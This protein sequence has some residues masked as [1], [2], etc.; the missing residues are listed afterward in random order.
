MEKFQIEIVDSNPPK[1]EYHSKD[2]N[3]LNPIYINNEFGNE[4]DVVEF[5]IMDSNHNIL[6]N[7]YDFKNY[8][9]N[10]TINNTNNFTQIKLNPE[11]DILS[12]GYSDGDYV[13]CYNFYR[14]LLGSSNKNH[15]YISNISLDRKEL[16]LSNINMTY[17]ILN[18]KYIKYSINKSNRDFYSDFI[19]NFGN[20]FNIIGVNILINPDGSNSDVFI[21]LYEP[22]P[23]EYS[24]K[25]T[26][27]ISEVISD[28]ISYNIS[29]EI[30]INT[31][32]DSEYLLGPNF[33][34]DIND[35]ITTNTQYF[36]INNILSGADQSSL[37]HLKSLADNIDINIDFNDFSNFIH[38]SS[39][40]ERLENFL[41]KLTQLE[42]LEGD[43]NVINSITGN[44]GNSS[45]NIKNE[46]DYILVNLD[47]YEQFLYYNSGSDS[48]PKTG[49]SKPYINQSLNSLE[50]KEWIGSI[51]DIDMHYGGKLLDAFNFDNSNRDYLWNNLPDY[52]KLDEQNDKL[53]L[54]TSMLGQHFDYLWTFINDI[55]NK[56]NNDNRLNV[57]ISKDLVAETLKSFGIKLYTNSRNNDNI[58]LSLLGINPDNT[59]LPTTG[60]YIIDNYVTASA[61]TI[62]D[63]DINKEVYK[64]IYNNLPYLL[65]SKGTKNGLKSL[66]NCFGIPETILRIKEYGDINKDIS[67]I[68]NVVPK[69]NYSFNGNYS[70]INIPWD[71]L[72]KEFIVSSTLKTPSNIEFRFKSNND[73]ST[74]ILQLNNAF[75]VVILNSII[76]LSING[77]D[78]PPISFLNNNWT[79]LSLQKIKNEID[80]NNGINDYVLWIGDQKGISSSSIQIPYN[81][82]SPDNT[83]DSSIESLILTDGFDGNVQEFRLW[84]NPISLEDFKEHINNPKSIRY[85]SEVGAYDNLVFRLPLGS[86]LDISNTQYISSSHPE[87]IDTFINN[88]STAYINNYQSV[89]YDVNYEN[90]IIHSPNIGTDTESNNK[91]SIVDNDIMPDGVLSHNIKFDDD[92]YQSSQNSSDIE[93]SLSPQD[94]INSDII[95]QLGYFNIDDYIGDPKNKNKLSYPNLESLKNYYFKK[96]LKKQNIFDVVRLLS[97]FDNSLFK[98]LKDFIP[99]S[100][101]IFTGLII[102][103]PILERNKHSVFEPIVDNH[104]SEGFTDTAFISGSSGPDSSFNSF[105][106]EKKS[107]E[108]GDLYIDSNDNKE[109]INGEY[110]NSRIQVHSLSNDNVIYEVSKTPT[111]SLPYPSNPTLNNVSS[112]IKNKKLLNVDY[113]SNINIPSNIITLQQDLLNGYNNVLNYSCVQDLNYSLGGFKNSRYIGCKMISKEY[114]KFNIGDKSYGSTSVIDYNNIKFAYFEEI[115]SQSLTLPKRSN[116]YIKYLIDGNANITEL[117]KNNKNLFDIQNIFN[118]ENSIDILLNNNNSPSNQ[119]QLDGLTSIYSG[120]FVFK[121]ILQ[122][123][124]NAISTIDKIDF[125]YEN[126][127]Q[128]INDSSGSVTSSLANSSLTIGNPIIDLLPTTSNILGSGS[129]I[130]S[131]K[132][133]F[134]IKFPITRNTPYPGEIRQRLS[135]SISIDINVEQFT[136]FITSFHSAPIVGGN[137][138]TVVGAYENNWLSGCGLTDPML[139]ATNNIRSVLVPVGA[140]VTIANAGPDNVV[141]WAT[142][143]LKNTTPHSSNRPLVHAG[144]GVDVIKIE[145]IDNIQC[146][147]NNIFYQ[148]DFGGAPVGNIAPNIIFPINGNQVLTLTFNIMGD[149]IIPEGTTVGNF[150]LLKPN[151]NIE[152]IIKLN[153]RIESTTHPSLIIVKDPI[154]FDQSYNLYNNPYY[155]EAPPEYLYITGSSDVGY[156]PGTP[157]SNWYFN[158]INSLESGSYFN[159]LVASY[160]LSEIIYNINNNNIIQVSP[161][162]EDMGYESI[163][164]NMD[165]N[166]GDIIRFWNYDKKDFPPSFENQIIQIIYPT[167]PPSISSY[168]NRL[169]IKLEKEIPNTSCLDYYDSGSQA[170]KIQNFIILSKKPD[171]TN[172]I[173]NKTKKT[174]ITSS[175]II[176]PS[177]ISNEI[178][179]KAGNIIKQLKNQNLI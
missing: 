61:Y 147:Y 116:I 72:N 54:F 41:Y 179:T 118:N 3:I 73:Q 20:N 31:V 109:F 43:L 110:G 122:N 132:N 29:K 160:H 60:S 108:Y 50:S 40:Y 125:I 80:I 114:N 145:P 67:I 144:S 157:Q 135:G 128:I 153:T 78:S 127:I 115:T 174:G 119:Q 76:Y 45:V 85:N 6:E 5:Y 83:F 97:Y 163:E 39:A 102:Q 131:F 173:I 159:T 158:R 48:F 64:R 165:I 28:S 142:P 123:I 133:D 111:D 8:S 151:T 71:N 104:Y 35:S 92:I 69:F 63:D 134:K 66:I 19:L 164:N 148:N 113:D 21:K 93:I 154:H 172:I 121:P 75:K 178:K 13:L 79:N 2:I 11:E 129:A 90:F 140:K 138:W 94:S 34:I 1:N 30:I 176:I 44:I 84:N 7:N 62:P 38:F 130:L 33:N 170:I 126:D 49:N 105:N 51:S 103:S 24:L 57:G 139:G 96:Y 15:F 91:I 59:F 22:L 106:K 117:T 47:K 112:N 56:H 150:Y 55:T 168:D 58:Y 136:D 101:D 161:E 169:I 98:M 77:V 175:G 124:T 68:E 171:E 70:A 155:Y 18:E 9:N 16:R 27:W 81:I 10:N 17:D 162:L 99:A 42:K 32:N 149:I 177:N 89:V 53:K 4:D 167:S 46:I 14:N 36:N 86:E 65:K 52:I 88:D 95:E 146:K 143:G 107:N 152:G 37:N 12:Y 23:P 156:N 87:N 141:T 120:G 82:S 137:I 166:V 26:L 74:K 100:S 25:D